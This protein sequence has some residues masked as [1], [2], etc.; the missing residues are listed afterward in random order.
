MFLG[1]IMKHFDFQEKILTLNSQGQGICTLDHLKVFVDHALP[2]EE[3][4]ATLIEKKKNF[5]LAQLQKVENPSSKRV[6]P[7]CPLFQK[8]GGCQIMHL[9]YDEQLKFKQ[10]KVQEALLKIGK[11][12]IQVDPCTPS[13][14]YPLSYRN[15][16]QL[17][18]YQEKGEIKLGLY[19]K[20]TNQPLEI[21]SCHI[22]CK[23]GE[24]VFQTCRSLLKKSSLKAFDE[25]TKKGFLR[26]L[27]IKTSENTKECLVVWVTYSKEQKQELLQLSKELVELRPEVKGVLMNINQKRFNSILGDQI[28][29]L[30]GRPFIYETILEK[31]FK[32]SAHSFFQ[33]NP[34]QAENLYKK[35]LEKADLKSG[36]N[37]LDAYC[38]TG[39]LSL[40][41]SKEAKKVIGIECVESAIEDANENAKL[42]E[43]KNVEFILGTV[44]DKISEIESLDVVFLNPP[45]RGCEKSVIETLLDRKPKKIIYISCDPATLARD[46]SFLKEGYEIESVSPFDMFPQTMHVETLVSLT[47]ADF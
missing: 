43:I 46:L 17:P 29:L 13:S 19:Q 47:L 45:R 18:I 41:A 12:E 2:G 32:I 26:H 1:L 16:I 40:L 20:K 37:V 21:N 15:K 9:K 6:K 10:N 36:K 42:N 35:A 28:S 25:K 27:L 39:T 22:H 24:K 31:S 7:V 5:G 4:T 14:Q 38:G 8:C 34:L 30:L 3:V 44:E 11:I 33:V 23:L